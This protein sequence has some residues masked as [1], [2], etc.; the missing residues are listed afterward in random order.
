MVA[1]PHGAG[2]ITQDVGGQNG[3]HIH[4]VGQK[5]GRKDGALLQVGDQVLTENA[6][7]LMF[8][9][10]AYPDAGL[11]PQRSDPVAI[12]LARSDLIW[13]ATTLHPIVRQIRAPFHYTLGDHDAVRAKGVEAAT[14]ILGRL[15]T[16]FAESH[17]WFDP[18]WSIVDAYLAWAVAGFSGA[19]DLTHYPAVAAH[20]VRVAEHPAFRK[21]RDRE[22]SA[23]A[24]VGMQLP[25]D[26][27]R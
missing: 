15:E 23:M 27:M 25:P 10:G 16:R 17:W 12:A 5:V 26:M 24:G 13:C 6:S 7:I 19:L 9:D 1:E 20:G 18:Q 2:G 8:L 14:L 3:V 4:R 22:A 11:L 21:M